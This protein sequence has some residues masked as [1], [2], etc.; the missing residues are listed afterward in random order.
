MSGPSTASQTWPSFP[1]AILSVSRK[2]HYHQPLGLTILSR[3]N[4][5]KQVDPSS[6]AFLDP[7]YWH[8]HSPQ[9]E[10]LGPLPS[11]LKGHVFVIGTAASFDS[12]KIENT[13]IY[14]PTQDGWQ[15]IYSGDGMIYRLD[16]HNSVHSTAT[17]ENPHPEQ[18]CA[19]TQ[20]PGWAHLATR[21][22]KT[23]DYY[24]DW[25]LESN[26]KYQ[27]PR[28]DY[29]QLTFRDAALTR[30]SIGLGGRN[31]LNTAWLPLKPKQNDSERLLVTW[32]AGRPYEVDPCSLGLV[33][34]VG[35]NKDWKPIFD[36]PAVSRPLQKW[37]GFPI[38]SQVFPMIL[39]SAHP[40]YDDHEDAVYMVNGTKSMGS[41]MQVS[42][43]Q[44]YFL[45]GVLEFINK[46]EEEDPSVPRMSFFNYVVLGVV[47]VALWL[48]GILLAILSFWEVGGTDRLFLYRWQGEQTEIE[49]SNQ[50]EVVTEK[51]RSIPIYQSV[52]Q[53][54][55]TKDYIVISDSSFKFVVADV[56]PSLFNPQD[57]TKNLRKIVRF[58][59]RSKQKGTEKAEP[60]PTSTDSPDKNPEEIKQE[61]KRDWRQD[62]QDL[63][64]FLNYAQTPYTDVY[65][66]AR[67]DL[68]S[69]D[70]SLG[71]RKVKAKHFRLQPETAH[72]LA[73]YDNPAGKVVL[74]VGHI[75]GLDPAEF[76]NK[77]DEA[78]CHYSATSNSGQPCP[79]D[80]N[81]A[82]QQ[83]SGVLA[84]SMA[85]NQLGTW[86]LNME[87]GQSEKV[88]IEDE[89]KFQLLAF[90]AL[91]E[92]TANQVTD[93][94][95]NC[96]GAWPNHHTLN[97]LDLY[98]EQIEPQV[99]DQQINRLAKEGR[100]AN[101]LRV[102]QTPALD[103][104]T[105]TPPQLKVEDYYAFPPGCYASSPQFVPREDGLPSST[106]GYI[107]CVVVA[108]D[109]PQTDHAI[110]P[111]LSE[112]W[113]FDAAHLSQG[114]LYR[115]NHPELNIG[116]TLHTAWLSKLESPPS[117]TDYDVRDDYQGVLDQV[118]PESLR[119]RIQ[120]LFDQDVFPK[121]LHD[122]A[123]ASAKQTFKMRIFDANGVSSA[124]H[125]GV[126]QYAMACGYHNPVV[127][128]VE[129]DTLVQDVQYQDTD[130]LSS[131]QFAEIAQVGVDLFRGHPPRQQ[132]DEP[133]SL[134]HQSAKALAAL[135]KI[136]AAVE[137]G[138]LLLG[139]LIIIKSSN[140]ESL[141]QTYVKVVS[142]ELKQ[143]LAETPELLDSS[144]AMVNFLYNRA[145]L[146][147]AIA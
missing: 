127:L 11:T 138:V 63:F 107:V 90:F 74:H 114:P 22:I 88:I 135:L 10:E 57:F 38:L 4:E 82:L 79:E 86:T 61:V 12:K 70:S 5:E 41:M 24:A 120:D 53:M 128:R 67:S 104:Q 32:D 8:S 112:L 94:Y 42:R 124:V 96:G 109:Y 84:N 55:L 134:L 35:L 47:N 143:T 83:R 113:I 133:S 142:E 75:K 52:H 33:A 131:Q 125:R 73:S 97:H 140:P 7:Q 44:P 103:G 20:Q 92:K 132:Y 141:P 43:L 29:Q 121:V 64:S 98:K 89:D 123:D 119:Q 23:P 37:F 48:V 137:N 65:V 85:P 26:P 108:T 28:S 68:E 1:K 13:E 69:G 144:Q 78:V 62:F 36:M 91:N 54:S 146:P 59:A 66:I 21:L 93:V 126:E 9:S 102:S 25:A 130:Q 129:E 76:V 50:W 16:F 56:L 2:E 19:T 145:E 60:T 77:I 95:W 3:K 40:V 105:S 101:L 139:Q 81:E 118:E 46:Q 18:P 27:K 71:V 110:H 87:T 147:D 122:S 100:P 58:V 45:K 34:P 99:L 15:H 49:E 31:Y 116:P 6:T 106:H 14:L 136:I 51:G 30:L 39:S 117:R 111:K 115:L 80:I 17:P 72:F